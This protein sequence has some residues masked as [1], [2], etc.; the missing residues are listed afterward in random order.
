MMSVSGSDSG[1]M[2]PVAPRPPVVLVA[3]EQDWAVRSL[4]SVLG[5]LGYAVVRATTGRQALALAHAVRPQAI[6]VSA[7]LHDVDAPALCR[8]VRDD[9]A[10]GPGMPIIVTATGGETRA[11]RMMLLREGAWEVCTQPLDSEVFLAKLETFVRARRELDRCG[12]ESLVDARTGFY[13]ARGLARRTREIAAES[14]RR[15]APL[16]CVCVG[17]REEGGAESDEAAGEGAARLAALLRRHG[18]GSDAIGML[19]PREAAVVAPSTDAAGARRLAERL[20][21]VAAAEPRA[22]EARA[23]APALP[24]RFGVAAVPDFAQAGIDVDELLDRAARALR[25]AQTERTSGPIVQVSADDL[26][27]LD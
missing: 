3:D 23:G 4:E 25:R 26:R 13:S 9:P 8:A 1:M 12:E 24:L 27:R 18:R 20:Q 7:Y 14:R 17:I 5:P 21:Q 15:R 2:D 16:A 19:G 10:L 6:L 22:A 11:E